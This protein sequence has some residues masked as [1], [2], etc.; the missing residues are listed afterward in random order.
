M[1]IQATGYDFL[2][3]YKKGKGN[4]VADGLFQRDEEGG[5]VLLTMTNS[6]NIIKVTQKLKPYSNSGKI[7][8]LS[9][10]SM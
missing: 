3:E 5:A 1:S 2:V 9:H 4:V 7:M 6:N 10:N 8:N